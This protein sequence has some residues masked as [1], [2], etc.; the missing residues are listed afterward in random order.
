M[1]FLNFGLAQ[2][3]MMA[4]AASLAT[5]ALY[6]LDRSRRRQVVSTLRFWTPA[7]QPVQTSRKR[8]LQQPWSLV[9]QLLGNPLA[10]ARDRPA[11]HRKLRS[12][13]R[14]ITS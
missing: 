8:K 2:F 14:A 12:R 3:V 9:L 10:A 11:A 5:V 1:F 6:L 7:R 4:G 13:S